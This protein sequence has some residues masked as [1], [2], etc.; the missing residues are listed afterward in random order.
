MRLEEPHCQHGR[1]SR[2][3]RFEAVNSPPFET[4]VSPG[5][6]TSRTIS[7]LTKRL[8]MSIRAASG[9]SGQRP[10]S[11]PIAPPRGPT[12]IGVRRGPMQHELDPREGR[13][14]GVDTAFVETQ[15]YSGHAKKR[16]IDDSRLVID[17]RGCDCHLGSPNGRRQKAQR[18]AAQNRFRYM[19]FSV[20]P[21]TLLRRATSIPTQ[22]H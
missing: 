2:A 4:P 13:T 14:D 18:F 21:C 8:P 10:S 9:G 1:G 20:W 17:N 16:L 15:T 11:R 3:S 6:A 5:Q 22:S 19:T 7:K 12:R